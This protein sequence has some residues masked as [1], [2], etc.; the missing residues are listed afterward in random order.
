MPTYEYRCGNC[1]TRF[2]EMIAVEDLDKRKIQCPK[3]KST[4]TELVI[5]AAYVKATKKS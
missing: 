2:A 3:C 5:G 1:G 4:N